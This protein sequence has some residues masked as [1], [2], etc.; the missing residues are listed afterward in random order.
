MRF[1]FEFGLVFEIDLGVSIGF[2]FNFINYVE[3]DDIVMVFIIGVQNWEIG[4]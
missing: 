3:V 2:N 4:W 1:G